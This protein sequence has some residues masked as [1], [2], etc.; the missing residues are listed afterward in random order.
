MLIDR[1]RVH[2]FTLLEIL[3]AMTLFGI[4]TGLLFGGLHLG[5]AVWRVGEEQ[6][7]SLEHDLASRTVLRRVLRRAIPH[8]GYQPTVRRIAFSGTSDRLD[9]V[10]LSPADAIPGAVFWLRLSAEGRPGERQLVLAWRELQW[11]IPPPEDYREEETV[12]LLTG[13]DVVTF[14][15]FGFSQS[16]QSQSTEWFETWRDEPALPDLIQVSITFADAQ[17][18]NPINLVVAPQIT[19]WRH[20]V[21]NADPMEH[22]PRQIAW[23][24]EAGEPG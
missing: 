21:R 16:G 4:L 10:A 12:V 11:D 6:L 8:F 20:L 2:G 14:E 17:V 5:T 9:F 1:D 18:R 23:S 3:V 7:E 15:Y 24:A 22:K 13:I 19:E